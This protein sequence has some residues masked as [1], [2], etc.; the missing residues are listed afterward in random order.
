MIT[1]HAAQKMF[2][3]QVH[4]VNSCEKTDN[5]DDVYHLLVWQSYKVFISMMSLLLSRFSLLPNSIASLYMLTMV[6]DPFFV[7]ALRS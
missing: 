5:C 2:H 6:G 4:K 1:T 3:Q 7:N